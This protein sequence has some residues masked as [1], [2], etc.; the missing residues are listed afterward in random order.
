M[1]K[2][3]N[4]RGRRLERYSHAGNPQKKNCQRF[5]IIVHFWS[6]LK[7]VPIR[8]LSRTN[9][10][11]RLRADLPTEP[12]LSLVPYY[13]RPTDRAD[14]PTIPITVVP[15]KT[16][17]TGLGR[18]LLPRTRP[19]CWHYTAAWTTCRWHRTVTRI[20]KLR[21]DVPVELRPVDKTSRQYA[22]EPKPVANT[23]LLL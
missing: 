18:A 13:Y 4:I 12:T 1:G 21:T 6:H 3:N 16:T 8:L 15:I 9:P 22:C 5:N 7:I 23:V 14:M 10:V 11:T 20:D 2:E 17:Q 19:R